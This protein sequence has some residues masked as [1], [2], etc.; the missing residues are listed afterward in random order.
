MERVLMYAIYMD[1]CSSGCSLERRV[2]IR[3]FH[4]RNHSRPCSCTL[5]TIIPIRTPP[6][7]RIRSHRIGSQRNAASLRLPPAHLLYSQPLPALHFIIA[8]TANTPN[9]ILKDLAFR[10]GGDSRQD[11]RTR[12]A[13]RLWRWIG[14]AHIGVLGWKDR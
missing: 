13:D 11:S 1:R 12:W 6:P 7:H 10:I 14:M 9:T 3:D 4:F 5:P 8:K 2:E